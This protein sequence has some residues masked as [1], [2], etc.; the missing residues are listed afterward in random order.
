MNCTVHPES[1]ATAYCRTC[2]KAMC[3]ACKH[4][5]Q[6]VIYCEDCLASRVNQP[7]VPVSADPD[8]PEEVPLKDT[9]GGPAGAF[10]I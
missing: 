9:S 1:A 7:V 8:W 10:A 2:G 5:V 6:G 3:D 4:T